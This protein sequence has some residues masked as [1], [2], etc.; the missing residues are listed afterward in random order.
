METKPAKDV[1]QHMLEQFSCSLKEASED[2]NKSS[3]DKYMT[4]CE[5]PVV[6]FD[7]FKDAFV[8]NMKLKSAPKS[9]DV[10]YR[11]LNN[12]DVEH[13]SVQFEDTGIETIQKT[14]FGLA[15][16]EKYVLGCTILKDCILRKY[17]LIQRQNSNQNL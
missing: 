7:A 4:L 14:L 1:Y 3:V 12:E 11:S 2:T 6:K 9:C 15:N 10:L 16:I 17:I 8:E 5:I 13:G